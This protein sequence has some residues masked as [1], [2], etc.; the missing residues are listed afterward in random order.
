MIVLS[1]PRRFLGPTRADSITNPKISWG[2]AR[3]TT[4]VAKCQPGAFW[5]WM[6]PI[7]TLDR[8]GY[9]GGRCVALTWSSEI[10]GRPDW[11]S[12]HMPAPWPDVWFGCSSL[13]THCSKMHGSTSV[14]TDFV[15]TSTRPSVRTHRGRHPARS[16]RPRGA[17][18]RKVTWFRSFQN[19]LGHSE[20]NLGN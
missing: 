13:S 5:S 7:D 18:R 9:M 8:S 6:V 10:D 12:D 14:G 15:Y 19:D 16:G 2:I 3:S 20:M 1:I 17:R 11:P 4:E